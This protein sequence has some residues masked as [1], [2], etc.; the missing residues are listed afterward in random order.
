MASEGPTSPAGQDSG[1]LPIE[2]TP[3]AGRSAWET[4]QRAARAFLHSYHWA[5]RVNQATTLLHF[6]K[7]F[8]LEDTAVAGV[9]THHVTEGH[10]VPVIR[11]S[12]GE[13]PVWRALDPNR[14]VITEEAVVPLILLASG[15]D[16]ILE[17]EGI[18]T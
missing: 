16:A 17:G 10:S 9:A 7:W 8:G 6:D 13:R 2:S 12:D 5:F 15:H 4:G 1:D 3:L 18:G 11:P 14:H